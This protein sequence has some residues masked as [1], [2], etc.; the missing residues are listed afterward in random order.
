MFFLFQPS[1]S[2]ETHG[3]ELFSS[4]GGQA[5]HTEQFDAPTTDDYAMNQS[6]QSSPALSALTDTSSSQ[7]GDK[8]ITS[9]SF[10]SQQKSAQYG[11]TNSSSS[12]GAT[13]TTN[14]DRSMSF[15]KR[16]T[17]V[18]SRDR[19]SASGSSR[20]REQNQMHPQYHNQHPQLQQNT[21]VNY[22]QRNGG[23][24]QGSTGNLNP[25]M[26]N[27]PSLSQQQIPMQ[28]WIPSYE[29]VM[30]QN[31][32]YNNQSQQQAQIPQ[33]Q[34]NLAMLPHHQQA[35]G[36]DPRIQHYIGNN[37]VPNMQPQYPAYYQQNR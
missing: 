10:K 36:G 27:N 21:F 33:H 16:T 12:G 19:S 32:I 15:E 18:G 25:N 28:Q 1:G 24:Q 22:R 23:S 20:Y 31:H 34:Q 14:R 9:S 6:L 29:N 17:G 13:A 2:N 4:Q 3:E 26:S 7:R 35:F 5:S 11:S 8:S 37:M 30:Y